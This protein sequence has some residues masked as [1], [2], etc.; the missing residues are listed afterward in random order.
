MEPRVEG[1]RRTAATRYC[2][3]RRGRKRLKERSG[4][5]GTSAT[6]QRT[7]A[8][9]LARPEFTEKRKPGPRRGEQP[10]KRCVV[11]APVFVLTPRASSPSLP[12]AIFCSIV[13][14]QKTNGSRS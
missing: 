7:T 4:D 10:V 9:R 2:L 13:A 5:E 14:W 11:L 3:G 12:H 6:A 8:A 1:P